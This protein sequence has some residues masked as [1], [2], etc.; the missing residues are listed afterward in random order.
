MS[1]NLVDL[2]QDLSLLCSVLGLPPRATSH[3]PCPFCGSSDGLSVQLQQNAF[4]RCHACGAR[5]DVISATA[6]RERLTLAQVIDRLTGVSA[7]GSER[8]K[9]PS[10]PH[11]KSH[12]AC[13]VEPVPPPI[14]SQRAEALFQEADQATRS[15]A[16]Y[17]WDAAGVDQ[18][19]QKLG[20]DG[21]A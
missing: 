5:G 11:S 15:G 4:F 6:Q 8:R 2:K 9:Y 20:R 10:F 1:N 18:L 12:A 14:D 3:A 17:L 19:I 7:A 16:A 13:V 21:A